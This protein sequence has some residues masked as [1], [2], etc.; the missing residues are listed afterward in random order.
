MRTLCLV[1]AVL[2]LHAAPAFSQDWPAWGGADPGRNMASAVTGLPDRF[3]PGKPKPGSE[4]IDLATTKNV[5]WIA[6]LGSQTYGNTVVAGGKVFVGTNNEMPRDPRHTGDRSILLCLDEKTGDLLW[7]LVVPKLKAGKANDWESLGILSSPFVQGRRLWLVTSRNEVLCLDT[8][9]QANGNDGPFQDEAAYCVQ[10][11]GQPPV[12]PGPK[13]ADILWRFDMID[14]TGAFPHNAANCSVLVLG[15]TLYAGTGNGTDWTHRNVPC[16][17]APSL[18]ALDKNTGRLLAEDGAGI[19][20]RLFHGQWSSPSAGVV[21]GKPLVFFG[22]GDGWLYAFNARPANATGTNLL[23]V[24]WKFDCNPP[25]YKMKDGEPIKYPEANGPSEV[26]ATPAFYD[27]RVYV[28]TGQDPEQGDGVGRLVCVDAARGSLLWDN[29]TVHRS[30]S[31]VSI[32]P[33]TG[34]LFLADYA[35]FLYCLDAKTGQPHWTY[36]TKAHVWGSTLV[37]DGRVHVGDED[38]D[39]CVLAASK[40]K[41]L[42]SEVNL[43]G[44]VYS[45]P[46][47][48]NGV[49]YVATQTHLYAIGKS[50]K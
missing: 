33:Q 10:D 21:D 15:D 37:A 47:A 38:G 40:E 8:E 17:F 3:D 36:D 1:T 20:P 12:A 16:P 6:R 9:G 49:I 18:L 28:A 34:L 43:G 45:T 4:D 31:T 35:G 25:E 22:A 14:Q 19:G 50:G 7:Q 44:P 48:A 42:I 13:D 32:D 27:G 23:S 5:R 2:L 46:V 30:L 39:F 24:A 29:K 41:K 26:N 11:T